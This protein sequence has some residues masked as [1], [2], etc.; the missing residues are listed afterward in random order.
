MDS[1]S[2]GALGETAIQAECRFGHPVAV[3]GI[4]MPFRATEM[5]LMHGAKCCPSP[6]VTA[7]SAGALGRM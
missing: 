6:M 2:A 3:T 4:V 5:D 1:V 7:F